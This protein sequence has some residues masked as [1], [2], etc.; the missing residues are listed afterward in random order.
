MQAFA[1]FRKPGVIILLLTALLFTACNPTYPLPTTTAAA[2]PESAVSSGPARL[3]DT[4]ELTI[5]DNANTVHL[6]K[7]DDTPGDTIAALTVDGDTL[8]L[9]LIEN[10]KIDAR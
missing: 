6:A 8:S 7:K 3:T 1:P 5:D 9:D 2:P 10:L 4:L